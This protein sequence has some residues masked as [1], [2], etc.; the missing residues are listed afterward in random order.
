MLTEQ[1]LN[2]FEVFGFLRFDRLFAPVEIEVLSREFD[3]LI[4]E[5]RGSEVATGE[6]ECY[7]SFVERCSSLTALIDDDRI[8][9]IMKA[10]LGPDL[11][12]VTSGG[13]LYVG[14]SRWHRDA[15][16]KGYPQFKIVIYL[17]PLRRDSGCL[18]VIPGSHKTPFNSDLDPL[19]DPDKPAFHLDGETIPAVC[20]ETNSGDVVVFH[21][22][23]W[24][25]T[26]G[27]S[28]QRRMLSLSWLPYPSEPYQLDYFRS[29]YSQV[30]IPEQP[31][32]PFFES[33]R[34]GLQAMVGR[35][36]ALGVEPTP[37][38]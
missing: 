13:N 24:H 26:F 37:A 23:I 35:L 14:D 9:G 7:Q 2:S 29:L 20:L 17:D 8:Y 1:Q 3:D 4:V 12:W 11:M 33:D 28:D 27:G 32:N 36:R 15:T 5:A 21:E 38:N 22:T 30:T 18:R 31:R 16:V 34:P 10:I 25:A 19:I 6:R